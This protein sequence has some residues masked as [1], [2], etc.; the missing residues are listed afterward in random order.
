MIKQDY[1]VQ[2][3]RALAERRRLEAEQERSQALRDQCAPE[4]SPEAR[5][6]IWERLHQLRLPRAPAHAILLQVAQQTGLQ[7]ADLH[8]VQRLRAVAIA[9]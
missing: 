2:D 9:P 1:I 4:N 8:E 7:M 6:R 3:F 5:V